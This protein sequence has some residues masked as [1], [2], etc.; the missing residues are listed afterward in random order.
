[1]RYMA[2]GS[3]DLVERS[4]GHLEQIQA[5]VLPS[6][7]GNLAVTTAVDGSQFVTLPSQAATQVTVFNPTETIIEVRQGGSGVAVPVFP[8]TTFTFFGVSNA[9]DLGIR[10]SDEGDPVEIPVRWEG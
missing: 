8:S 10:R 7:G 3:R 1:M 9:N 2:A 4:N 5:K 6:I